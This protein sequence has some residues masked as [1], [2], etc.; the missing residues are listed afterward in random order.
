[1]GTG[2]VTPR[3][4]AHCETVLSK[5]WSSC[6]PLLLLIQPHR[7][8][9]PALLT[10]FTGRALPVAITADSRP[11]HDRLERRDLPPQAC[12]PELIWRVMGKAPSNRG[13]DPTP[14]PRSARARV[15]A[16]GKVDREVQATRLASVRRRELA[17]DER[18]RIAD[19]REKI[20]DQRDLVAE[21]RERIADEREAAADERERRTDA[22]EIELNAQR[23]QLDKRAHRLNAEIP[24]RF[25]RKREEI[26]RSEV[27]LAR[28]ATRLARSQA[29]LSR[30]S[31]STDREQATLE[32]ELAATERQML[33]SVQPRR[34]IR[35]APR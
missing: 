19:S 12:H 20:A 31:S 4:C 10:G 35:K 17:T 24:D 30:S 5:A 21:R 34:G 15:S 23:D 3:S 8:H 18:D 33:D 25:S 2:V 6:G 14:G 28:A 22:L 27:T 1:M 29:A 32:R 11:R 16:Q 7:R 26:H 13:A 9:F